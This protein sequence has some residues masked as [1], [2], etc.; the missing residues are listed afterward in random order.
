MS[1]VRK[2]EDKLAS[3]A[4]TLGG[5]AE[6]QE[7]ANGRE[8]RR[9]PSLTSSQSARQRIS[10]APSGA[11]AQGAQVA[12][13]CEARGAGRRAQ[14]TGLGSPA[15]SRA[16]MAGQRALLLAGF[17]LPGF[18]LSEAA[19][20]L[21]LSLVGECLAGESGASQTPAGRLSQIALGQ[22]VTPGG[23]PDWAWVPG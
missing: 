15:H 5:G 9:G 12:A 10:L 14:R 20:I 4:G 22:R 21:T 13:L 18:L 2:G 11:C 1:G 16:S 3:G 7:T 8:H 19:K 6:G 23:F 17:L